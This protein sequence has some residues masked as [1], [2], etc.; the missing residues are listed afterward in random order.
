MANPKE[1][2][3]KARIIV[4]EDSRTQAAWLSHLLKGAGYDFQLAGD[5]AGAL[6][7]AKKRTP[8]L[9]ISDVNMPVMSGYELCQA[10]REDE[11]LRDVPIMLLTSLDDPVSI[12]R[13]LAAGADY[14]VTKP[15]AHDELLQQVEQI[16]A[17]GSEPESGVVWDE[18]ESG[19]LR[20]DISDQHLKVK[21]NTRKI[22]QFLLSTYQ[23]A[24]HQKKMLIEV[25]NDLKTLNAN[26]EKEIEERTG[27]LK[28][29][30]QSYAAMM[31]QN[32]DATVILDHEGRVVY[33]NPS[34]RALLGGGED[35]A[36]SDW[37]LPT[38]V[39]RT[40]EH[41]I[42]VEGK[43]P[44][45]VEIRSA[46]STWRGGPARLVILRDISIKK[47][48]EQELIKTAE[49]WSNCFDSLDDMML[50]TDQDFRIERANKAAAQAVGLELEDILGQSYH[51]LFLGRESKGKSCSVKKALTT[52]KIWVNE[53]YEPYLDRILLTTVSPVKNGEGP[54]N[55][56][57]VVAKDVSEQRRQEMETERLNRTLADS[58][59]GITE[60]L[61][62]LAESQD[63]YIAGHSRQVAELA[64]KIGR[65]LEL[66]EQ[67]LTGL[68]V[69]ALLHDI[70]KVVVPL[71]I[72]NK[73]GKLSA[74]EWG[75]IQGHVNNAYEYLKHIP[76]P[77]PVAEVV[78]QHHERLN[79]K[80][81]PRKLKA[82]DIHLWARILAA[83]DVVD[84][85]I[86]HRPYRP[87]LPMSLVIDEL[88]KGR[89]VTYD[90]LV[91][92]ACVEL[93]TS[94]DKRIMVVDDDQAV[95]DVIS[96]I[97][98][99][100]GFEV[101]KHQNPQAALRSFAQKSF[102][103]VL[104][105]IRM[106][107]MDGFEFLS[108]IHKLDKACK[109]IMVTGYGEKKHVVEALRMGAHNFL[110]KPVRT[111]A[112]CQAVEN[113]FEMRETYNQGT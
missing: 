1:M 19:E 62:D 53:A 86:S 93:I 74:N 77:W 3:Q 38:D 4:A 24:L 21:V 68:R 66:S 30:E 40:V 5:G 107:G 49:E 61:S 23:D 95:L 112:V 113:A 101:E 71:G 47:K 89:G 36:G 13:G 27:Q 104:T 72:L 64:L 98:S 37:N 44:V 42:G 6:G 8:D 67:D 17:L 92:D 88:K 75:I 14:Y 90:T 35:L 54:V 100:M 25:Q 39:N 97:I 99:R 83:A 82:E 7:L 41:D 20:V 65:K 91:V 76:F 22:L 51:R 15:F 63:P 56:V 57:V 16:L 111:E 9:I 103:V 48:H 69:C 79:G 70:G 10:V 52:G 73:P 60:A 102:P 26:L 43:P 55:R 50:I 28:A 46:D 85:M 58:F 78:Y 59:S 109:V 33:S 81:Y 2:S 45:T 11:A 18:T 29:S 106:P 34:A 84:A 108:E 94:V 31:E 87:G 32:P 105:D 110:E 12:I 80:G 96:R